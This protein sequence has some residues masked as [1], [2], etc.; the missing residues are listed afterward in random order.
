[1]GGERERREV[2]VCGVGGGVYRGEQWQL[3][4]H[5]NNNMHALTD[6]YSQNSSRSKHYKRCC[7]CTLYILITLSHVCSLP[8][9]IVTW[10]LHR[11]YSTH[12]YIVAGR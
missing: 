11:L 9:T 6:T 7:V 2:C 3:Y 4:M 10:P 1:M 8:L 5:Y 12:I